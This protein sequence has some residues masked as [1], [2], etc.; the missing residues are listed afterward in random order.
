MKKIK[1]DI[2]KRPKTDAEH[3]AYLVDNSN[4]KLMSQYIEK[5]YS[6]IEWYNRIIVDKI[7]QNPENE[8]ILY[9]GT[10]SIG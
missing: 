8:Y 4:V 9:F 7:H 2:T 1:F 3:V 10:I 5:Y 6:H